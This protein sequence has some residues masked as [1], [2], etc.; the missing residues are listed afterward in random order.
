MPDNAYYV[1]N[2]LDDEYGVDAI[3][4]RGTDRCMGRCRPTQR[5]TTVG[6]VRP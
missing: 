2:R 1:R 6:T 5:D 4:D 3:V